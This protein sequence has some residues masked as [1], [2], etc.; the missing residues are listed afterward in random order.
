M[1]NHTQDYDLSYPN[2]MDVLFYPNP[3]LAQPAGAVDEVDAKVQQLVDDMFETLYATGGIGLAAPQVGVSQRI[4][5]IDCGLR[6]PNETAPLEPRAPRALINPVILE[7]SDTTCQGTEA[8]LSVPGFVD[9]VER[10]ETIKVRALNYEGEP[11]EFHAEGLSAVC[12]QHEIDHLD[13]VLFIDRLSRLRA[14]M[15]RRRIKKLRKRF[16]V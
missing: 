10:Y 2:R 7:H 15:V 8:C 3:I 1:E 16:D 14:D 4:I 12:I 11:V 6:S 5:V 13:G 9:A